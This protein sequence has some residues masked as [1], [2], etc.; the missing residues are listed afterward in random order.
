M[1]SRPATAADVNRMLG[2]VDALVVS[3][4]LATGVTVDE[5]D[6]ALR[7]TEDELGFGEESHPP[8]SP[9]VA[10]VRQVLDELA[11]EEAAA[12]EEGRA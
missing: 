5:L 10:A 7:A 8:S 11:A 12:E 1:P 3:R 2:E 4:I 9:R 6:E